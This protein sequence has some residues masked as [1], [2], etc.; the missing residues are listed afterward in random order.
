M[1]NFTCIRISILITNINN[2]QIKIPVCLAF[3]IIMTAFNVFREV[4]KKKSKLQFI[5]AP[6]MV[7]T[8][9][10]SGCNFRVR[11]CSFSLDLG[12]VELRC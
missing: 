7:I 11:N 4:V 5:A 2:F 9:R 12:R 10:N 6:Q 8:R 1:S 3:C